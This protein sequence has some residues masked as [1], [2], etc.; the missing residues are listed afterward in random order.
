MNDFHDKSIKAYSLLVDFCKDNRG[1]SC[2]ESL[3]Q[4]DSLWP[5]YPDLVAELLDIFGLF[6]EDEQDE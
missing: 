1:I 4:R 3:S 2:K 5:Q 6:E